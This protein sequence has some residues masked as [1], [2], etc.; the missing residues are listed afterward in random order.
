MYGHILVALDGSAPGEWGGR[1][2][3]EL[4]RKT[5]ASLSACHVYGAGMH[6]QRFEDMEPGLPENFREPASLAELRQTHGTLMQE[7]FEAL[8]AGFVEDYVREA[9]SAGLEVSALLA[10]G[11]NYVRIIDLARETRADLVVLGATGLG[12]DGGGGL[13]STTERV[14]RHAPCDM[15]IARGAVGGAVLAGIDGS[16]AALDAARV[17]AEVAAE[18]GGKLDLAAVYDPEFHTTVFRAMG[19]ALSPE[20]QEQVGL[21]NQEDLHDRIINDG[22]ATLYRGFLDEARRQ[23]NGAAGPVEPVLLTGKAHAAI[24]DHARKAAAG[25]VVVGRYGHHREAISQIGAN[26]ETLV[27]YSGA[28][29]LIVGAVGL[30]EATN[31]DEPRITPVELD[32]EGELAWDAEAEQC[33]NRI[34]PFA[35]PMA[36][37]AIEAA[38]QSEGR[39]RVTTA[40][41]A[42]VAKRFGMAQGDEQSD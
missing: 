42:A 1:I 27:R 11:R 15:L 23:L 33:L 8:S 21:A 31:R 12:C 30:P 19:G 5:G 3:L 32:S 7:G 28:N 6:R 35:R 13:G 22:L 2:A 41:F 4:A 29:V 17:A 20:R 38:V 40:D 9:R 24:S 14:L 18:L 39:D 26:A 34:P 37:R 10:E 36:R 25:L 16:Q